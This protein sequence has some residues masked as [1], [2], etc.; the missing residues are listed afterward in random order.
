M[1]WY[2]WRN[3]CLPLEKSIATQISTHQQRARI[4]FV[5]FRFPRVDKRHEVTLFIRNRET[6]TRLQREW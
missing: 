4:R 3:M 5:W 6:A 2:R 1:R